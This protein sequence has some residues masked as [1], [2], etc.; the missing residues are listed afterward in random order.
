MKRCAKFESFD[1]IFVQADH[2]SREQPM[3][4][5]NLVPEQDGNGQ[6]QE[7]VDPSPDFR[8][9]SVSLAAIGSLDISRP[10]P[11]T[12]IRQLNYPVTLAMIQERLV[13]GFYRSTDA[14]LFD[15]RAFLN[16]GK[17]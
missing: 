10:F 17:W 12:S 1:T 3:Q 5:W 15:A 4:T 16:T 7:D 14:I 11:M 8:Q 9:I 6:G 2:S 13:N